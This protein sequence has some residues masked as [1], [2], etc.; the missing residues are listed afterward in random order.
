MFFV[1]GLER[2]DEKPTVIPAPE[3]TTVRNIYRIISGGIDTDGFK[4]I[5]SNRR[6]DFST[7]SEKKRN[8]RAGLDPVPI[9]RRLQNIQ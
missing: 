8:R 1:C 3:P 9:R 5:R 4:D 7:G 6:L 2:G